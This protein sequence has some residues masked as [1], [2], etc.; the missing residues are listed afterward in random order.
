ML[1]LLKI[2]IQSFYI[3]LNRLNIL[4]L[5]G[6]NRKVH[7]NTSDHLKLLETIDFMTHPVST[8]MWHVMNVLMRTVPVHTST[9]SHLSLRGSLCRSR[10][11]HCGN[12]PVTQVWRPCSTSDLYLLFQPDLVSF[13]QEL[14]SVHWWNCWEKK[15][16]HNRFLLPLYL[17][18]AWRS[19]FKWPPCP[20]L[21]TFWGHT[22]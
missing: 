1:L 6:R 20:M 17:S 2:H 9:A 19:Q 8:Q 5:W 7:T 10:S 11:V 12:L 13:L 15:D 22:D 18:S 14:Y 21:S 4:A 16:L 3:L